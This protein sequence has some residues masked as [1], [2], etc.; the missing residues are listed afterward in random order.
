MKTGWKQDPDAVFDVVRAAAVDWRTVEL[1]DKRRNDAGAKP[2]SNKDSGR[3]S[4]SRTER[5]RASGG[6]SKS[7]PTDLATCF[8]RKK[9]GHI[10][11]NCPLKLFPAKPSSQ[12]A[13]GRG[14]YQPRGTPASRGPQQ[15]SSQ[16]PQGHRAQG[17]QT[18]SQTV[19]RRDSGGES[20]ATSFHQ[21]QVARR[22]VF[23]GDSG[24]LPE[25]EHPLPP[26]APFP[27][28]ET[29]PAVMEAAPGGH[30]PE[31]EGSY[32][33]AY[34]SVKPGGM[35]A[36]AAAG[37]AV[38]NEEKWCR[39][40]LSVPGATD[41]VA[42]DAVAVLDS[43]SGLSTMSVGIARKLQQ[44]YP[45][46]QLVG[47]MQTPGKL[48]VADGR[49]REVTEKTIPVRIS[50]HTSWGLVSLDP[51]SFA[52]MPGDDD[53][54]ILGNPTLKALGID[55]YE[56]L[57]ARE[58]KQAN[59][60]SVET[61]AYK[62]CRRVSMSVDALHQPETAQP[63]SP[64]PAVERLLRRGPDMC[65]TSEGGGVYGPRG[66]SRRSGPSRRPGW[67]GRLARPASSGDHPEPVERFSPRSTTG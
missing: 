48:K 31:P 43:G 15:Q 45:R 19:G 23:A 24:Q 36:F 66:R 25:G 16:K 11:Q 30:P 27:T 44:S 17:Q 55:V 21:R 35:R 47:G 32:A 37:I 42:V 20:S 61:A 34:R 28:A 3:S 53:V 2:A 41:M 39:A 6:E 7:T 56:S 9:P 67:Y 12:T 33:P 4:V 51:F 54:V 63:D 64:D 22:A 1:A 38:D 46:V 59:I 29:A 13:P 10:A 62:Q 58:R 26:P 5:R 49:L 8:E 50:L 40:S 18:G 14:G 52:V 57:G 60:A 65:L